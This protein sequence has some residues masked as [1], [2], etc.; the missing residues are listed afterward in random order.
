MRLTRENA[1]QYEGKLLDCR[2]MLFH[3]Y[4]LRVV[5]HSTMGWMYVDRF[6]VMMRIPEEGI[7]FDSIMEAADDGQAADPG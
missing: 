6:H 5:K 1:A 2:R 7:E 3:Y 4:P